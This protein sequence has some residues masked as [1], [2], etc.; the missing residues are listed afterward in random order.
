MLCRIDALN[1]DG[2]SQIMISSSSCET[3]LK[4][5]DDWGFLNSIRYL[6]IEGYK[7]FGHAIIGYFDSS[8]R[9][10]RIEFR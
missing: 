10:K 4:R 3:G 1:R 2:N 8:F 6:F 5:E 9:F 7:L